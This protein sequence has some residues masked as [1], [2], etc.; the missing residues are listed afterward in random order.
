[1]DIRICDN[2]RGLDEKSQP[3]PPLSISSRVADM[4]GRLQG[5]NL[6]RGYEL[7]LTIPLNAAVPA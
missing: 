7:R 1:M 5:R 3:V 4:G 6:A 2:G